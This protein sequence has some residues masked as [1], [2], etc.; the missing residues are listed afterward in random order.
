VE[1]ERQRRAQRRKTSPSREGYEGRNKA[2]EAGGD[3]PE[4]KAAQGKGE[5]FNRKNANRGK[6]R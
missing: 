4:T 5:R 6:K 1:A 2:S 3:T